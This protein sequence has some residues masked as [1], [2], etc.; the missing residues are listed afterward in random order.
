ML[1]EKRL[2]F[3]IIFLSVLT[4]CLGPENNPEVVL[5]DFIQKQFNGKLTRQDVLKRTTGELFEEYSSMTDEAFE[6]LF[7]QKKLVKKKVKVSFKKCSALKCSITFSIAY[8]VYESNDGNIEITEVPVNLKPS[9]RQIDTTA[10]YSYD[11]EKN[12]TLTSKITYTN[13]LNHTK[14]NNDVISSFVGLKHNNLK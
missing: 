2:I 8:D 11:L 7:L 1:I 9:G 13:E 5:R 12:I 14:S 4:S 3:F 10:S 6:S